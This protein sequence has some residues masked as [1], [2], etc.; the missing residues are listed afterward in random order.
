M[1]VQ[2][3]G[4]GGKDPYF[5]ELGLLCCKAKFP[6]MVRELGHLIPHRCTQLFSGLNGS[7]SLT[8]PI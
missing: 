4:V 5:Q 7:G 2:D 1:K 6:L 3:L 8:E